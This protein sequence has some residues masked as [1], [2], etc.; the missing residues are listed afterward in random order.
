MMKG[1]DKLGM[2]KSRLI[3]D[4]KPFNRIRLR[5]FYGKLIK[6]GDL[7]FDIGAHTGNR[8]GTW[9]RLGAR[10][11]A[12]EPQ[13]YFCRL[14]KRKYNKFNGF[15]LVPKAVSDQ[16]GDANL[17][18]SSLNPTLSTISDGWKDTINNIAPSIKWDKQ[19]S[20]QVTT[21]QEMTEKFGLPD[22]C[23]IDVE[24]LEDKVLLGARTALPLLSFEFFPTTPQQAIHCINILNEKGQYEFNW[25]WVETFRFRSKYW[26]TAD[27][28]KK[29]IK[30]YKKPYSGDIYARLI[31]PKA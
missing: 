14:L 4:F 6:E 24:G 31:H 3:Y 27:E 22:F 30:A 12:A 10:V 13:P 23:K 16:P 21:L 8:T 28:M 17:Q 19:V 26:L 11:I 20:V 2:W 7:C 29:A 9:L 25:V 1:S 18:I 5:R 15:T